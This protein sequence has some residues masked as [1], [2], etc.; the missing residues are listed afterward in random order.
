M[1]V[2]RPTYRCKVTGETRTTAVYF[3][4]HRGR[5]YPLHVTDKRLAEEKARR[6]V[7]E[8]ELGGDPA[9]QERAKRESV[10]TLI[11]EFI[12]GLASRTGPDHRTSHEKRLRKIAAALGAKT[13]QELDADR[14]EAWLRGSGL[15]ARTKHH[16][17]RMLKQFGRFLLTTRRVRTNPFAGL[18]AVTGIE[19]DRKLRRRALTEAEIAKLLEHLPNTRYT[20]LGLTGPERATLYR[21]VLATGLRRDEA[22]SLTPESFRLDADV[23]HLVVEAPHTKNKQVAR[24]PL[25]AALAADLKSFLARKA[26][27]KPVWPIRRKDTAHMVRLDLKE[28]GVTVEQNGEVVDMHALRTTFGTMLARKSVPLALAQKLMRHCDPRLT[29]NIYTVVQLADLS[30]EVE[31]LG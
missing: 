2:F 29:S 9:S 8:L 11:N 19:Q 1:K 4:R 26:A 7:A 6:L 20:R 10:E 30:R 3:L 31:K 14:C 21:V 13:L 15:A 12:G 23:P 22:A 28:A 27:G 5:R 24:Q 18:P 17:T 25:P 16:Y